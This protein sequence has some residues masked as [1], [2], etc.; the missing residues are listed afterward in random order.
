MVVCVRTSDDS[1]EGIDVSVA[2]RENRSD[3]FRLVFQLL[4]GSSESYSLTFFDLQ[5]TAADIL[6]I[7]EHSNEAGCKAL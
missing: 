6:N 2:A 4:C 7:G 3:T 1:G 5:N